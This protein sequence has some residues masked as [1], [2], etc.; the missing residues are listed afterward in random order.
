MRYFDDKFK[1]AAIYEISLARKRPHA[2]SD[3]HR[4]K[5][6]SSPVIINGQVDTLIGEVTDCFLSRLFP[7]QIPKLWMGIRLG[8]V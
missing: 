2:M 8:A 6:Q 1:P 7:V 5:R 4:K 3:V